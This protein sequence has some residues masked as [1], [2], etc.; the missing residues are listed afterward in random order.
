MYILSYIYSFELPY[1]FS[2]ENILLIP[3]NIW[4]YIHKIIFKVAEYS[5]NQHYQFQIFLM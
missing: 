4:M 5:I 3:F 1:A 2:L